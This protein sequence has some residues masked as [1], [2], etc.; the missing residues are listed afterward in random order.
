MSWIRSGKQ[1][2][3]CLA[4]FALAFQLAL[5]F[6]HIHA[7]DIGL[8]PAVAAVE[9]HAQTQANDSGGAPSQDD[10]AHDI[11]AICLAL[12]LTSTSVLPVVASLTL[13]VAF[14]WTWP[15]NFQSAQVAFDFNSYY[16]A[17]APPHA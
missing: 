12:S 15:D 14:E 4:L 5:S 17:R 16:R 8:T 7:E 10:H 11:C 13:P 2:G 9:S 1:W 6:G 3:G